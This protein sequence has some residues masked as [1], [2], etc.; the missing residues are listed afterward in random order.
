MS[1]I[2]DNTSRLPGDTSTKGNGHIF[3]KGPNQQAIGL[4]LKYNNVPVKSLTPQ[5]ITPNQVNVPRFDLTHNRDVVYHIPTNYNPD[6][7]DIILRPTL[8]Q[9][10]EG[11]VTSNDIDAA[12]TILDGFVLL[13]AS[14]MEFP[15][16]A[17]VATIVNKG[18]K[19]VV[20]EDLGC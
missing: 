20:E 3:T 2:T 10:M 4:Q 17:R 19:T 16:D 9:I 13:E 5:Y 7:K 1:V 15:D 8:S 18:L 12:K 14:K 11:S 6:N